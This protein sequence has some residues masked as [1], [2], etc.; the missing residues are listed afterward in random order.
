MSHKSSSLAAGR[1]G[2]KRGAAVGGA[3]VPFLP[4]AARQ[5]GFPPLLPL[6]PNSPSEERPNISPGRGHRREDR[7]GSALQHPRTLG[8]QGD[9]VRGDR[10]GGPL[11]G[12]HL[13]GDPLRGGAAAQAGP[14]PQG[15]RASLKSQQ[16]QCARGDR[17]VPASLAGAVHDGVWR[18]PPRP[19]RPFPASCTHAERER[20]GLADT[21]LGRLRLT[22]P[23]H[24][25][26]LLH[27]GLQHIL[28]G[29]RPHALCRG[30]G[31][32]RQ[33]RGGQP[34]GLLGPV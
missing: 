28:H 34:R 5:A 21:S 12:P 3:R 16:D 15:G 32:G 14:Y 29:R 23:T 9:Q 24:A 17:Y 10:G 20:R 13:V 31:Q 1:A 8:G 19:S 6:R 27:Q 18:Q 2:R 33:D 11:Q 4:P 26:G 22:Q 7:R 30:P 25:G